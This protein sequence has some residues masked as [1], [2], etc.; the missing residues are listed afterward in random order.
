MSLNKYMHPRNPYKVPPNF[1]EMAVKYPDFRRV[2]TQDLAGKIHLDFN[3]PV[4]LRLLTETLFLKDFQ[5][6]VTIPPHCLVPTLPSRMNYL[7]WVEDLL[8]LLSPAPAPVSGLDIGAGAAA[9]YPLLGVSHF[10]WRMAATEA[11]S[12]N[13]EAASNNLR[14]NKLDKDIRLL[15]VD[16]SDIFNNVFSKCENNFDFSMCNPPF[17]NHDKEFVEE[18]TVG[19]D[20]EL[21]TNG[22]EVEFVKKMISESC[23]NK[24]RVKIFTV[25]LGHKSSLFPVKQHLLHL[26]VP[27][28]VTTEF[29]QGKTMRWGVAWTYL[30]TVSLKKIIGTKAK[31]D[32]QKPF[33]LVLDRPESLPK[34]DYTAQCFYQRIKRWLEEI[35]IQITTKKDTKYLC[36]ALLEART[37]SWQNQRRVKREGKRK[38]TGGNEEEYKTKKTA[39]LECGG[40]FSETCNNLESQ[41]RE[42]NIEEVLLREI[43]ASEKSLTNNTEIQSKIRTCYGTDETKVYP[44]FVL[45]CELTV[46]WSGDKVTMDV[47]Y[48]DGDAGRDG[49]HQICQFIKNNFSSVS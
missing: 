29:C 37:K 20:L 27:S 10:R 41:N 12:D 47:S 18:K 42:E 4:A 49:V 14:N 30:P 8:S 35:S 36:S 22:G 31:K 9:V 32:K 44:A 6:T 5:L 1:K 23:Q 43:S 34:C 48:L 40:K 7:L 39:G 38:R 21:I 45:E 11:S 28:F 17:Y 3:N 16:K 19:S 33:T 25:L 46:K 15:K 13:F 26:R 24:T 2:V